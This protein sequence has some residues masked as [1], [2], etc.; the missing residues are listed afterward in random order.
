VKIRVTS[1]KKWLPVLAGIVAGLG[2]GSWNFFHYMNLNTSPPFYAVPFFHVLDFFRTLM[3]PK[4]LD[5]PATALLWFIYVA[6][7]G[8]LLGFLFQSLLWILR[9]LMHHDTT[10]QTKTGPI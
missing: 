10:D 9:R 7:L 8:A 3:E 2:F 5:L 4:K 6:G 1:T